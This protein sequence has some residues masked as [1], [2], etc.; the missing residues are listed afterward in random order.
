MAYGDVSPYCKTDVFAD[1]ASLEGYSLF[2]CADDRITETVLRYI[3]TV[4]TTSSVLSTT[5]HSQRVSPSAAPSKTQPAST[6]SSSIAKT[7]DAPIPSTAPPPAW[8]IAGT[9]LGGTG[10]LTLLIVCYLMYRKW[11]KRFKINIQ[12]RH[13]AEPSRQEEARPIYSQAEPHTAREP[14]ALREQST[15]AGA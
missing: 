5:T 12:R 6:L 9:V 10:A 1:D 2:I 3:T 14:G 13:A 4:A 11:R 8:G 15:T 7:P